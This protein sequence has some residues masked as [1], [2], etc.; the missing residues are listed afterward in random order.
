MK[1]NKR[2]IL[3]CVSSPFALNYFLMPHILLNSTKY[4]IHICVNKSL[5]PID[6]KIEK[7]AKIYNVPIQRKISIIRD[8]FSLFSL[9]VI[10]LKVRPFLVQ[11]ITHKA[12][13]LA[14]IASWICF[15]PNRWYTFTGQ[16]WANK[17]GI[18]RNLSKNADRIICVFASKLIAD[19]WSQV[20]FLKSEKVSYNKKVIVLGDG[21]IAGVDTER[22]KPQLQMRQIVRQ[23]LKVPL[24]HVV[25]LFVGRLAEEKGIFDLS[26]AYERL[27]FLTK[28]KQESEI[29]FVGPDDQSLKEQLKAININA[30]NKVKFFPET[31]APE[32]YMIA[33]DI[34]CLPSYREGFGSVVI[35]AAA[36]GIPTIGYKTNGLIDSVVNNKTG[37]LVD[38]KNIDELCKAMLKLLKN[39]EMRNR[40]GYNA[41]K[42]VL[43]KFDQNKIIKLYHCLILNTDCTNKI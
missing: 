6:T 37:I 35:E 27:A 36:C 31:I 12:G 33:A 24:N 21:S 40:F 19:S 4:E 2:K 38:Y 41:R 25:F 26:Y 22:F 13:L 9:I 28:K 30:N 5:Y 8:L 11:S 10:F 14:M 17:T 3:F 23:K 34:L 15:V 1:A 7:I 18:L 29:W 39:S 32:K 20:V 42:R 16:Y 43:Q